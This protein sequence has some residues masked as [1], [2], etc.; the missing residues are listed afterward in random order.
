MSDSD[1]GE[2]SCFKIK[3]TEPVTNVE[4]TTKSGDNSQS[5]SENNQN[6]DNQTPFNAAAQK[7]NKRK[8]RKSKRKRETS[9][10][11]SS[12]NSENPCSWED[13]VEE[14]NSTKS[15]RFQIISK[16]ESCKCELPGEIADYVSHQFECPVLEKDVEKSLLVLQPIPENVRGIKK[17]D[18]F[19]KSIIGQGAQVLNQDATMEKF[20]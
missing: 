4:G 9:P 20:Q 7:S 15:Y 3:D 8:Q 10:E 18:T 16:S 17:L 19:V 2:T 6:D 12:S 11:S 1:T 13:S 14:I 5:A